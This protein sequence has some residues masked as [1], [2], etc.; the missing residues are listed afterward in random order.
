MFLAAPVINRIAILVTNLVFGSV[1]GMTIAIGSTLI[2]ICIDYP[3]HAIV[4]AQGLP[5]AQR[6]ITIINKE[7]TQ[8]KTRNERNISRNNSISA[9]EEKILINLISL[10]INVCVATAN[11]GTPVISN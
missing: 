9:S 2:G 3:I 10:S 8:N 7:N 4:H 5:Q 6:V 11:I 1:H